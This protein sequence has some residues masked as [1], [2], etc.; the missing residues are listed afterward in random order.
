MKKFI[1]RNLRNRRPKKIDNFL[2][3]TSYFLIDFYVDIKYQSERC[4]K[5]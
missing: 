1:N 2:K 3:F 5:L 4:Y